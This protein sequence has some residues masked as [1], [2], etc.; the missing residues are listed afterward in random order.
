MFSRGQGWGWGEGTRKKDMVT[1]LVLRPGLL[2]PAKP[3]RLP[4]AAGFPPLV[5]GWK[6]PWALQ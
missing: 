4:L 6:L 5:P 3:L 1:I 2:A